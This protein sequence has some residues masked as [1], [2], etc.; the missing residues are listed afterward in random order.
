MQD[1]LQNI[2]NKHQKLAKQTPL[3]DKIADQLEHRLS[4]DLIESLSKLNGSS[5]ARAQIEHLLKT[6][7]AVEGISVSDQFQVL[8]FDQVITWLKK[9][10]MRTKNDITEQFLID[11]HNLPLL[12]QAGENEL[13]FY[14]YKVPYSLTEYIEW[15]RQRAEHP[16]SFS[17]QAVIKLIQLR[18]FDLSNLPRTCLLFF[19]LLLLQE[20]FPLVFISSKKTQTFIELVNSVAVGQEEEKLQAFLYGMVELSLEESL[21]FIKDER[22]QAIALL[23][24]GQLAKLTNESVPTIRHWTNSGL[25]TVAEHSKGGYQLY[26]PSMTEVVLRIRFLQRSKRLSVEEIKTEL[27]LEK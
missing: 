23:K 7:Q 13:L 12:N 4:L 17:T 16:V 27:Q 3:P 15:L 22:D 11:L 19:T 21:S 1:T 9:S 8:Q 14:S 2:E 10:E 5:L 6:S 26:D 24:I 18:Q 25:L 20:G